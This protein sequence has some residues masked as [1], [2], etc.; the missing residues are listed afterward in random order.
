M[1]Q[2]NNP[3]NNASFFSPTSVGGLIGDYISNP[4]SFY[5]TCKQIAAAANHFGICANHLGMAFTILSQPPSLTNNEGPQ[6][7]TAPPN[8]SGSRLDFGAMLPGVTAPSNTSA[9]RTGGDGVPS[10]VNNTAIMPPGVMA[11]GNGTSATLLAAGKTN[12]SSERKHMA[13]KSTRT[14]VAVQF[15]ADALQFADEMQAFNERLCPIQPMSECEMLDL[16]KVGNR[17]HDN[18]PIYPSQ[19]LGPHWKK[20]VKQEDWRHL[21]FGK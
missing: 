1:T 3:G 19:G 5:P 21:R 20:K 16:L 15:I 17:P 7:A 2:S 8:A 9:I 4:A 14:G 12:N 6:N 10:S 11:P 18:L 13:S